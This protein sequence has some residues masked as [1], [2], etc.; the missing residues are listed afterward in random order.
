MLARVEDLVVGDITL[1]KPF[2]RA[3]AVATA[4]K[5]LADQAIAS[6][7]AAGSLT[8]SNIVI[9]PRSRGRP[10]VGRLAPVTSPRNA[11]VSH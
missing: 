11:T 4:T 6:L 10:P 1:R 5:D 8:L 3:A 2:A 7:D 9:S